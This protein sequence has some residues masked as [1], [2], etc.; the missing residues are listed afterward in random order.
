MLTSNLCRY[1]ERKPILGNQTISDDLYCMQHIQLMNQSHS[2]EWDSWKMCVSSICIGWNHVLSLLSV[3]FFVSNLISA[4]VLNA[5]TISISFSLLLTGY[6]RAIVGF[7]LMTASQ[8]YGFKS[9]VFLYHGNYI[10]LRLKKKKKVNTF[11]AL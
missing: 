8:Q 2:E 5:L 9:H 4:C 11:L 3:P 10:R 7:V 6:F 1:F